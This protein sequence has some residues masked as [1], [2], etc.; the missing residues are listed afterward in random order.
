MA[1]HGLEERAM[2]IFRQVGV[3]DPS[4]TEPYVLALKLANRMESTP[5]VQWACLGILSQAWPEA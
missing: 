4:R 2:K 3:M 5:D 1:T